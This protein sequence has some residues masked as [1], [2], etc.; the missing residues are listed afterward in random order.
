M[1]SHGMYSSLVGGDTS[2]FGILARPYMHPTMFNSGL[3]YGK[4]T[5]LPKLY[6]INRRIS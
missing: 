4:Y 1:M 3:G 5:Y 2:G 6:K